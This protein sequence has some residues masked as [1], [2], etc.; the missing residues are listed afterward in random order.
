ML[1]TVAKVNEKAKEVLVKG[2]IRNNFLNIKRL[3]HLTGIMSQ[4]GFKIK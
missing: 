2:Y 1:G 3:V 4:Q